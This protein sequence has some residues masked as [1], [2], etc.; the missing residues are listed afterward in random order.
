MVLNL[1]NNHGGGSGAEAFGHGLALPKVVS[2]DLQNNS[3]STHNIQ[4]L[5]DRIAL[6]GPRILFVYL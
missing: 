1:W 3:L 6:M 2:L 4:D 5:K